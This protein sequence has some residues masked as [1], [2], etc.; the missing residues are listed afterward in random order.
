MRAV[1]EQVVLGGG[2]NGGGE[3]GAEFTIEK[4]NYLAHALEGESAAAQLGDDG[5]G[6]ELIPGIDAAMA[7]AAGRHEAALVP[8]LELAA[9]DAGER[10]DLGGGEL[11]LHFQ[12]VLFQTKRFRN[13]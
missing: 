5:G 10:D 9:G 7:L 2:A 6:Y 4:C 12:R 13:V 11:P 3:A 1:G 8:P